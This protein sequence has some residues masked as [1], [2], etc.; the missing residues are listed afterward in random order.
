MSLYAV[1]IVNME[2]GSVA[3]P[4]STF[5]L[6]ETMDHVQKAER[7]EI[8]SLLYVG[9]LFNVLPQMYN[10]HCIFT[11]ISSVAVLFTSNVSSLPTPVA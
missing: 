2:Q 5:T 6:S 1:F 4:C 7:G 8:F 3:I 9:L 11:L 10:I